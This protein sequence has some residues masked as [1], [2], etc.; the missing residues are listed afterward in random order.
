M[1]VYKIFKRENASF[2][3]YGIWFNTDEELDNFVAKFPKYV[4]VIKTRGFDQT[5][6]GGYPV[7]TFVV[8][9]ESNAKAG[10]VNEAGLKR[11]AKFR[12]IADLD[13]IVETGVRA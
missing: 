6:Q 9:L 5:R 4:R 10:E 12:E 1:Q 3:D 13:S 8:D 2:V 11:L 7:A